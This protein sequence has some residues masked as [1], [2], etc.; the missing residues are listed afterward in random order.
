[1]RRLLMI[2]L[3]GL[4]PLGAW[5][6]THTFPATDTDNTFTGKNQFPHLT[7]TL[8]TTP[9]SP[10]TGT[11]RFFGNQSTGSFDCI[12]SSGAACPFNIG[13]VTGTATGV[14]TNTQLNQPFQFLS[15]GFSLPA[16]FTSISKYTD[17]L[18][19]GVK[20]PVGSTV[21]QA[22]GI[23][24]N[25]QLFSNNVTAGVGVFGNC[26][27][28]VTGGRCW[29]GNF[30]AYAGP[31][32]PTG[33]GLFGIEVD[34]GPG[35]TSD[36]VRGIL[37]SGAFT[38]QPS[39]ANGVEITPPNL[40]GRWKNGFI[41]DE[42]ALIIPGTCVAIGSSS[43]AANSPSQYLNFNYRDSGAV[44]RGATIQT[45]I[46]GGLD[47]T[48]T[49]INSNLN[50][51]GLGPNA[52]APFL[53]LTIQGPNAKASGSNFG[54]AFIGSAEA[55]AS[56]PFGLS[57]NEVGNA[58]DAL[59]QIR[60]QTGQISLTNAGIL[61]LQGAGGRVSIGNFAPG[62]A[63]DVTGAITVSDQVISTLATGTAPLAITST[64]PV[65]NLATTPTTYNAGGTQITGVHIVRGTCTLG[66]NCNVT[67]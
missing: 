14:F 35:S 62:T 53:P 46:T 23:S 11:I 55:L 15:G 32:A 20:V 31:G 24:G 12:N 22:N 41:C 17:G 51:L 67:L 56:N 47:I 6:Q 7:L 37:V 40:S 8:G 29:G 50:G 3:L 9:A 16:F 58:A 59:R 63:L 21:Y 25:V 49:N 54:A 34:V 43:S 10:S 65:A 27:A 64:T 13:A 48:S 39:Q 28:D 19:V 60:L 26:E 36:S 18:T 44:L 42:G 52:T 4:L 61:S 1:M 45:N 57:I 30:Q 38:A 66:T 2:V 33:L 5:G